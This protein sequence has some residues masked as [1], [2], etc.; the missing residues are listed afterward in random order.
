MESR[1]IFTF[2]LT[3]AIG[4]SK[5]SIVRLSPIYLN[6]KQ[7]ILVYYTLLKTSRRAF[8]NFHLQTLSN[9]YFNNKRTK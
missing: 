8:R 2:L 4:T 3:K 1:F 9:I 6:Q 5:T 7:N